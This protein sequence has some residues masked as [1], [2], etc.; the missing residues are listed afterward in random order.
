MS[1]H[2]LGRLAGLALAAATAAVVAAPG[3]AAASSF[4]TDPFPI[5]SVSIAPRAE[6]LPTDAVT[7]QVSQVLTDTQAALA[8]LL[9]PDWARELPAVLEE[10][11]GQV[12]GGA[13]HT[14]ST[15]AFARAPAAA[16]EPVPVAPGP[17]APEPGAVPAAANSPH[18]A[19]LSTL[20]E[21][22]DTYLANGLLKELTGGRGLAL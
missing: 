18:E 13:T 19:V 14:M 15:A 3:A 2:S 9:G 5:D 21:T 10:M 4:P 16:P 17:V 7:E 22:V 11:S 8:E 12:A 20:A 1:R 6:P